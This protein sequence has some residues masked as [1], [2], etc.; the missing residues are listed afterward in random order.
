MQR[1]VG[2]G[3]GLL[4]WCGGGSSCPKKVAN[5]RAGGTSTSRIEQRGVRLF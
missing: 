5:S 3:A 2:G 1:G 4:W